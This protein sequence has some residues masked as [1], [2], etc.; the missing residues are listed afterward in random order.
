MNRNLRL[1]AFCALLA[2]LTFSSCK[3]DSS[4]N[5]DDSAYESQITQH[6]DD[7]SRFSGD[8]DDVTNDISERLESNASFS[9]RGETIQQLCNATATIDTVSNP[10]KITITYNGLNCAGTRSRQGVVLITMAQGM[11]W[12]NAGAVVNVTYQNLKVTRVSDNKSITLNGT[13]SFT[14]VSGGLLYQLPTLN[15]IV[16]TITSSNMSVTFGD[17]TQRTWQVARKRT[18]TY[19]NGVVLT[20]TGD[21]TEGSQTG[22]AEWGLTRFGATFA[23]AITQ[24]VVL[25]QDCNFRITSGQVSHT[26]LAANAVVTFGLDAAGNPTSCPTGSNTY[27]FKLVWTGPG[28]NSH[29]AIHPY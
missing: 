15:T 2:A 29:T 27:Y 3:K 26:R 10:R 17:S 9:G 20:V 16:H 25:R 14:N 1:T 13:H 18:Y 5:S 23:T 21:H 12:K 28:G 19:N 7:Q 4:N 6:N 8:M 24:P 22:I 11:R